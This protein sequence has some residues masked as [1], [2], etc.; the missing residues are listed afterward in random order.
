MGYTHRSVNSTA[1]P[2]VLADACTIIDAAGVTI[3]GPDGTGSP[4]L[5]LEDGIW[6]NG[7][8][9]AGEDYETFHL[10]GTNGTDDTGLSSFCKTGRRP[11]DIVITAI[12]VSV[13]VRNGQSFDTD[14]DWD[15]WADGVA[16]FQRAVRHLTEDE[17]LSLEMLV[18]GLRPLP[19]AA[20]TTAATI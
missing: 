5:T 7:S 16:L 9:A 1:S 12:F 3:C 6:L 10:P 13:V 11:Y 14:G 20:Q 17:L 19:V 8:E 2:A 4:E 15:D 18:T